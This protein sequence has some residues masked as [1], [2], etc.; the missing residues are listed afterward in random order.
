[1]FDLLSLLGV[2]AYH[3]AGVFVEVKVFWG[4]G[5]GGGVFTL[6]M[7]SNGLMGVSRGSACVGGAAPGMD[8]TVSGTGGSNCV[9]SFNPLDLIQRCKY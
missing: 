7:L 4:M 2:L 3:S 9:F 6:F 5:V 8:Y 1:M